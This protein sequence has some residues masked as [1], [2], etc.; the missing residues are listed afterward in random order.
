MT[1]DEGYQIIGDLV[2]KGF[3]TMSLNVGGKLIVFKT[4]NEKEFQLIKLYSG[5]SKVT[6]SPFGFNMYFLI[7]SLLIVD[8]K[9]VLGEREALIPELYTFFAG[10]PEKVCAK[11]LDELTKLREL[12]YDALKFLEGYCYTGYSRSSWHSL[13]GHLPNEDVVT[14]FRGTGLLGLNAHQENWVNLNRMLDAEEQYNREFSNALFIASASNPKGVKS[15]RAQHESNLE[16]AEKRKKRLAKIGHVDAKKVWK[17][18]GWSAPVDTAEEL[19]AELDRQMTGKKDKH[20]LFIEQHLKRMKENAEARV[21]R[22]KDRL[23]SYRKKN[24]DVPMFDGETRHM[25]EE[26][27]AKML[28]RGKKKSYTTA[29]PNEGAMT[30]DQSD[31]YLTKVG[32]RVL[33]GKK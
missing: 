1:R 27:V 8:G 28:D 24:I 3:L 2:S 33:T 16:L 31:K 15:V 11:M 21:Q 26:E 13:N 14:G 25:T 32:S 4:I 10:M 17:P 5:N 18:E 23:E 7:H 19:L 29:L 12:S 30:A 9:Y 22:A 20:D 6:D